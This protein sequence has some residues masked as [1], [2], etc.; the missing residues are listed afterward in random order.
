VSHRR[1][2]LVAVP[3][4]SGGDPV[5]RAV[6][7][8]VA[9]FGR[10]LFDELDERCGA[11]ASPWWGRSEDSAFRRR[12]GLD[13]RRASA[14]LGDVFWDDAFQG[15]VGLD[16]VDD[17]LHV[18]FECARYE[19]FDDADAERASDV[20]A[21]MAS[22]L[23]GLG[24]LEG[25]R[26]LRHLERALR[27]CADTQMPSSEL[28]R[29]VSALQTALPADP[30]AV[31]SRK[32]RLDHGSAVMRRTP[33]AA[34]APGTVLG[35]YP[36]GDRAR[37]TVDGHIVHMAT[38]RV[39]ADVVGRPAATAV[40]DRIRAVRA[41][42]RVWVDEAGTVSSFVDG[43]TV[44]VTMVGPTEWFGDRVRSSGRRA[45]R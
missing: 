35:G 11:H 17:V 23:E 39:L 6:R 15:A 7:V 10:A 38:E 18:R 12:P 28:A 5:T 37:V 42:G 27:R 32:L 36:R 33:E 31:A 26:P 13:P 34:F 8:A 40:L 22:L 30:P 16:A 29:A 2:Q 20:V 19:Q 21:A 9:H 1:R 14:L 45:S 43:R 25:S 24:V 4:R 3:P 44:Y 41:T